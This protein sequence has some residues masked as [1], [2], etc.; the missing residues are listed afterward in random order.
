MQERLEEK[1]GN[2]RADLDKNCREKVLDSAIVI[3]DSTL[4]VN[5]RLNRESESPA[6]PDRPGKPQIVLPEDTTPV[7]P[8]LKKPDT[9]Q[10]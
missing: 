10:Q 2:W 7:A 3:V 6:L 9:I 5:A 4:I 1:L 8:L